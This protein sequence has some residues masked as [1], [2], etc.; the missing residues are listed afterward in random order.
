MEYHGKVIRQQFGTGSKS[1]HEAVTLLT[2]T[3]PLKLSPIRR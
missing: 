3:G 1:E 2:S